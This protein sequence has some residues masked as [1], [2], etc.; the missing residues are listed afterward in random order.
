LPWP[1]A[2]LAYQSYKNMFSGPRWDKLKAKNA[3]TQRVLWA[4]TSTKSATLRDVIYI[5]ELIGPDTVNT[6]PPSTYDAFRDHGVPRASLEADLDEAHDVMNTLAEV[7][8]DMKQVTQTLQDQGR[9]V[10]CRSVR[11]AAADGRRRSQDSAG[12]SEQ[13]Q[14]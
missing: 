2:K 6:I 1:T 8:I 3:Q 5:E 14:L 13:L 10:V 7:G 11:Q 12:T 4:S 9:Q